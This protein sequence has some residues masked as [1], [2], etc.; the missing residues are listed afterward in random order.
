M[1]RGG[2]FAFGRFFAQACEFAFGAVPRRAVSSP[3][4]AYFRFAARGGCFAC[5]RSVGLPGP[6]RVSLPS[7]H[8]LRVDVG[9]ARLSRLQCASRTR[10]DC[11]GYLTLSSISAP[12]PAGEPTDRCRS[13]HPQANPLPEGRSARVQRSGPSP[14]GKSAEGPR[15][16]YFDE[17]ARPMHR[18]RPWCRTAGTY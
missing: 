7:A 13:S 8:D 9:P 11:L 18:P 1:R 16:D 12:P 3:A 14:D 15:R 17:A 6:F 10:T 4:G 5:G 2:Y